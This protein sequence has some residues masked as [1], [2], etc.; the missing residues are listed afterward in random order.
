M[1]EERAQL[2]RNELVIE[3][4][5]NATPFVSSKRVWEYVQVRDQSMGV[6][7]QLK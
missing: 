7:R 4:I 1:V 3:L 2:Q 6:I 5:T